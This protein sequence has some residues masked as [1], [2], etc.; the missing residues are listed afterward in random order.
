[1]QTTDTTSIKMALAYG[2]KPGEIDYAKIAAKL[3][4]LGWTFAG[5]PV[6][7]KLYVVKN[8]MKLF[9]SD[10]YRW[11]YFCGFQD[12][13]RTIWSPKVYSKED[14]NSTVAKLCQAGYSQ[15]SV[16]IA[17]FPPE[18]DVEAQLINHLCGHKEDNADPT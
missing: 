15:V 13:E 14:A 6:D 4:E 18:P 2:C 10:K 3:K 9:A 12:G 1:M 5:A 17:S 8:G 11:N 16:D 7:D